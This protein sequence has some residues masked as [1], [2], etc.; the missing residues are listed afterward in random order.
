[1]LT[2]LCGC[3]GLMDYINIMALLAKC[4]TPWNAAEVPTKFFNWIDKA[5]RQL[6]PANIQVGE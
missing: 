1:M 3:W 5:R 2:H 4:N 6:A